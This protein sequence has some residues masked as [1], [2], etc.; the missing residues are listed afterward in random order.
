MGYR[1]L[2]VYLIMMVCFFAVFSSIV[3]GEEGLTSL[4]DELNGIHIKDQFIKSS[5]KAVGTIKTIKGKG[6]LVVL[7]RGEQTAYYA[8]AGDPVYEKD[9]LYTLT[10]C[11]CRILPGRDG[12]TR[13]GRR[14]TGICHFCRRGNLHGP[15]KGPGRS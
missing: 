3:F 13:Q 9:A 12:G 15:G 7:R 11:R 8:G 5:A 2:R 6:R 10:D 14:G 1:L 4:P